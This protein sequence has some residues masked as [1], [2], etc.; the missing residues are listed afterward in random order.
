MSRQADARLARSANRS[1]PNEE[2]NL[3]YEKAVQMRFRARLYLNVEPKKHHIAVLNG[4]ILAF[5]AVLAGLFD[6]SL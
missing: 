5:E 4:V 1:R 6:C 3:S 2:I